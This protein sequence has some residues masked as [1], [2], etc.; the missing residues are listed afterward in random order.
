MQQLRIAK[1]MEMAGKKIEGMDFTE[2]GCQE[3]VVRKLLGK[4][5]YVVAP[6]APK[7]P[8]G[9]TARP[10]DILRRDDG[11]KCLAVTHSMYKSCGGCSESLKPGSTSSYAFT[12]VKYDNTVHGVLMVCDRLQFLDGTPVSEFTE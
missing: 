2:F 12:V 6:D 9:R 8:P 11:K 3:A 7:P 4:M 5:G 1:E 10:G